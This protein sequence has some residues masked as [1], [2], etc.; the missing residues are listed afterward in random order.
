[1]PHSD[2]PAPSS[3]P[4]NIKDEPM[5]DGGIPSSVAGTA[6]DDVEMNG[7]GSAVKKEVKLDELFAD[8]DSD[9]EEFPSSSAPVKAPNSS[10]PAHSGSPRFVN[11][12]LNCERYR[13]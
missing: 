10:P 7:H 4:G 9:D 11:S 13:D 5:E 2:P 12:L 1:M 8:V 3:P 6:E